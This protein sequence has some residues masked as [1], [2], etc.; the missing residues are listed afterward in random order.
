MKIAIA[1]L[2]MH[3]S[4]AANEAHMLR[5]LHIARD[6]GADICAF[7]E[8]AV[9]GFHRGVVQQAVPE[10]V[11]PALATLQSACRARCVAAVVGTPTWDESSGP[12]PGALRNSHVFIDPSGEV[13]CT[14]HKPGL[15]PAEATFFSR[16]DIR[17]Q[18]PLV[19][20]AGQRCSAVICREVEDLAEVQT[21]FA[22]EQPQVVF[23]PGMMGPDTG[24]PVRPGEPLRHIQQACEMARALGAWLVQTNWPQSLNYPEQNAHLGGSVVISPAG[25]VVARC[26]MSA[27][28]LGLFT[29]GETELTWVA[30]PA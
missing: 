4:V 13:V 22:D 28:G 18:R 6:M 26:P 7:A 30:L 24:H 27:S 11:H 29:L 2:A 19:T 14:V 5:A 17:P 3:A 20:A 8:L 15:T 9:T 1:Q 21:D 25:E 23:W 16:F 10:L 12:A